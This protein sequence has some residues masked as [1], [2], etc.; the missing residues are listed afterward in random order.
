M[1]VRVKLM[2]A[3]RSKLP[4]GSQGGVATLAVEDGATLDALLESL[5]IRGGH[6]HLIM[7]NGEQV[8]DRSRLLKDGEEVTVFPPVAGGCR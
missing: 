1:Q 7:I 8:T 3:L 2:A 5:G 6:I 4:P